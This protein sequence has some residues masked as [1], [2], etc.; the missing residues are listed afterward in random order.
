M[1][2]EI[3]SSCRAQDTSEPPAH[4]VLGTVVRVNPS[5]EAKKLRMAAEQM[6]ILR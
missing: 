6:R 2:N 1:S 5:E 4:D 3:G